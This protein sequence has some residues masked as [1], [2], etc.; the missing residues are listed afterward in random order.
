VSF[1]ALTVAV[2]GDRYEIPLTKDPAF[3]LMAEVRK[4]DEPRRLV[5]GWANVA[6]RKDGTQLEDLHGDL[7]DIE[8]LEEAA[9]NFVL[10]FATVGM[11]DMHAGPVIG[12][13]VESMVFTLEKFRALATDPGTGAS[14]DAAYE[15]LSK[16]VPQGWWVGFKLEP[17]AFELVR[18][19]DRPMMS[20][21][22][23]AVP[24]AA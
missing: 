9:Y 7:I 20:I 11:N 21:E 8:D 10:N 18:S 13:P 5:F 12:K 19:G 4:I 6:V 2:G 23:Y 22:G 3:R 16:G 15:A 17:E 1:D 14:D 24:S